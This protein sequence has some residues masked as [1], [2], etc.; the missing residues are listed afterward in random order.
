M[1][2]FVPKD[3]T[4]LVKKYKILTEH[5][6]TCFVCITTCVA[7]LNISFTQAVRGNFLDFQYDFFL[8]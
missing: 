3:S 5:K 4:C 8:C 1:S 7:N 2:E 6:M